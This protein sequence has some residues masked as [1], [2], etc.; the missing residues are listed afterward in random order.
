MGQTQTVTPIFHIAE[1]SGWTEA[2]ADGM[3]RRS[4]LGKTLDE[5]GF[6]HCSR[7]EQ[8]ELVANAVY[9]GHRDLILL[10]IDP[11]KVRAEIREENLD[12]GL[13]LFPHIYGPLNTDAVTDVLPF[14]PGAYGHFVMPTSASP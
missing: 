14:A 11:E 1:V 7:R 10:V 6:I 12:G 8:V 9:R 4:T 5:L 3:Y 2:R 13:D